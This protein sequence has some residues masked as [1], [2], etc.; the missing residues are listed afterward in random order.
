M[1]TNNA[2]QLHRFPITELKRF[3]SKT[4][5]YANLSTGIEAVPNWYV[6]KAVNISLVKT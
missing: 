5:F 2:N 3:E 4:L 1:K 6:Y